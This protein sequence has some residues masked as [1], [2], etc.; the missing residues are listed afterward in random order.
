M[1]FDLRTKLSRMEQIKQE[2]PAYRELI[3]F[4]E[5]IY[6]E[7]ERCAHT[8]KA[9]IVQADEES[10]RR[11][12]A[13][14]VP[15]MEKQTIV[16]EVEELSEFFHRLL[17]LSRDKNPQRAAQLALCL[18]EGLEVRSLIE[19]M[20]RG[21]LSTKDWKREAMGDPSLLVF[22]L[23]ESLKPM[24]EL[25][26][27][28]LE[29]FIDTQQWQH[30]F[31]P[32]CGGSPPIGVIGEQ[33]GARVLFCGYCGTEWCY[34]ELRCPFCG[35]AEENTSSYRYLKN[36]KPYRIEVCGGCNRYLKIVDSEYLGHRV[37]LD[38]EHLGTLHIDILA[39][40][41]GYQ[42]GTPLPLLI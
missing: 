10:I 42:R 19:G 33:R 27:S 24:Y 29:G 25:V 40:Q 3:E 21:D 34:P 17:A 4:Y 7:K 16:L 2:R 5:K 22:L 8:L 39:R 30:G 13:E 32:V 37:P 14:G 12:L 36:E 11:K 20:W 41:E 31:C 23:I 35:G 1:R 26:A 6:L 15:V 9:R 28:T 38:V 18:Q